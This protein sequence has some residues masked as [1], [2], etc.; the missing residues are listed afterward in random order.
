MKIAK[1]EEI[2]RDCGVPAQKTFEPLIVITKEEYGL[3]IHPKTIVYNQWGVKLEPSKD[4]FYRYT[5]FNFLLVLKVWS[6]FI[7]KERNP[8]WFNL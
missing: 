4:E 5:G 3:W 8:L 1:I 7:E 6:N 2:A